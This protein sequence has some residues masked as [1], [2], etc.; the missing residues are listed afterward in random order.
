VLFCKTITGRFGTNHLYSSDIACCR[1]ARTSFVV[2]FAPVS[3]GFWTVSGLCLYREIVT[4]DDCHMMNWKRML[5]PLMRIILAR[6]FN[7]TVPVM[8]ISLHHNCQMRDSWDGWL[9][10]ALWCIHTHA[11]MGWDEMGVCCGNIQPTPFRQFG[12]YYAFSS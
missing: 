8:L 11:G 6:P 3:S 4:T 9:S 12:W 7:G 10:H 5:K 1:C 2:V